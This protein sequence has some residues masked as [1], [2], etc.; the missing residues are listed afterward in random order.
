MARILGLD[1][2]AS[3]VKAVLLESTFRGWT[4][5]D[6]AQAPLDEGPPGPGRHAA[7]VRALVEGRGWSHDTAIVAFPGAGG[8]TSVVTLPF[9]DP[10]R[11]E[12]TIGFEVEGQ[13]PFDLADVSWDWQPLGT[14]DGKT[15]LLVAVVRK[16]ELAAL[17]GALGEVPVDPRGVLPA[18]PAYAAL[19]AAGALAG[20]AAPEGAD[21]AATPDVSAP[22]A[23]PA[24][25]RAGAADA[26]LAAAEAV[27]DVGLERT[28]VAV[29]GAEGC[30]AA[31][32][33][34]VGSAHLARALARDL[35]VAEGDA[36]AVVAAAAGGP[37]APP[38]LAALAEAPGTAAALRRALV[39]IVREVRATLRAW[40]ARV[41]ARPVAR[42]H[43][44]GGAARLP[45]LADAL[46]PEVEGPV[47][48]VALA[49]AAA[50]SIDPAGA[51]DLALALALALRGHL[52]SRAGRL[53]LRRGELAYTRD[54]EHLKGR[55]ARLGGYAALVVV[56]AILSAG[57]KV[58]ALARQEAA[59]DR[60]LC[61]AETRIIGRCYPNFEE[62]QAVLR[63]RGVPGASIP[64]V[65]GVDIFAEL[66]AK[67]P[68]GVPIRLDRI[69]IT[70]DKLHLQGTTD[71][72]ENVDRIAGALKGS[73][74]FADARSGGA[75]RRGSDAKFEFSIDA[76]LTC[77][78]AGRET[79]EE[80]R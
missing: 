19:A 63:G 37:P 8:S 56:V 13:I 71:A 10:R 64:R 74:C 31:R 70:K 68:E 55:I 25:E 79:P 52:G 40:R 11:I 48:P 36:A 54:F 7:A 41:G 15:E 49:G 26:D 73:R 22:P 53:N 30:E 20:S 24:S 62:A 17:L 45:A 80:R 3:A 21:D 34:A 9:T 69:E 1:L 51:P 39:P 43:L 77:L 27:V 58:F 42:L 76:S 60:A 32:T 50:A 75:R 2:G 6:A 29:V 65:S 78:E 35:G 44:A 12:Q 59:L 23:A 38:A 5:L 16:D 61:E 4:V 72:P 66:A 47:A 28:V 57:V 18:G 46:S 14:R 67:V 33:F